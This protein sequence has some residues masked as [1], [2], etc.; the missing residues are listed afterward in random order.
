MAGF[1][2]LDAAVGQL[3]RAGE[4]V[5]AMPSWT[6]GQGGSRPA[7][8]VELRRDGEPIDPGPWLKASG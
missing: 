1:Q 4:P 3:V 6:P 5:G 7:L 8:Y 2:K